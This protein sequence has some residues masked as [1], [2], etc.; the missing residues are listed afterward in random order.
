LE[1]VPT[2]RNVA[3]LW[4]PTNVQSQLLEE[5]TRQA[6]AALKVDLM[7]LPVTTPEEISLAFDLKFLNELAASGGETQIGG[8]ATKLEY[9]ILNH[10][11]PFSAT[12]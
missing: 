8:T 6:A 1:L 2:A 12:A 9:L 3:F 5:R 11:P 4:V 7:S 10:L